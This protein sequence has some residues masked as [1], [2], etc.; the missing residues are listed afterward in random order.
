MKISPSLSDRDLARVLLVP[1]M[2]ARWREG[3]PGYRAKFRAV[4]GEVSVRPLP[5]PQGREHT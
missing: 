1:G 4:V 2:A 5:G 3:G